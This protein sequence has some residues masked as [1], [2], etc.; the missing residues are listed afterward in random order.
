M[1]TIPWEAFALTGWL[2]VA[3]AAGLH[4]LLKLPDPRAAWG[5]IAVTLLFPF[6]GPVLYVLFG[7]NRVQTRARQI[8][9]ALP[10]ALRSPDHEDA[11]EQTALRDQLNLRLPLVH[12]G[13]TVT[14]VRCCLAMAFAR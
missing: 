3:I 12:T 5:W 2:L 10:E 13:D 11:R 6:A 1:L 4:A 14:A 7:I 8:V 9:Q